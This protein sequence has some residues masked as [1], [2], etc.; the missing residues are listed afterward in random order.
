MVERIGQADVGS[1]AFVDAL[2]E[3]SVRGTA[4][5]VTLADGV[6]FRDVV[7]EVVTREG[8]NHAVFQQRGTVP[9]E[10]VVS[11]TRAARPA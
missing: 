9:A 4:V 2:E 10:H 6:T 7:L 5:D 1:C 8:R 3:A 11:M